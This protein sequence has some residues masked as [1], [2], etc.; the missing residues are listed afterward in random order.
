MAASHIA[1][2]SAASRAREPRVRP[3]A[4]LAGIGV[5]LPDRVLGSAEVEA[6]VRAASPACT[7]RDGLVEALTGVRERRVA[8][9]HEQCS[10]LAAAAA[11]TALGQAGVAPH[12]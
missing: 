3:A 12:D 8:A 4:R 5:Q 10:D 11:R 6:R 1:P 2:A 9:A 7:V